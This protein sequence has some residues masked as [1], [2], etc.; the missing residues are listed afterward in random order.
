[1]FEKK[2]K[3]STPN[4]SYDTFRGRFG[5]GHALR[6]KNE[7]MEMTRAYYKKNPPQVGDKVVVIATA[8]HTDMWPPEHCVIE[9]IT[10]RGRI[11]VDHSHAYAWAGKSFWKS[12]Q[13]CKA[14]KGQV[15]LIPD[16]LYEEDYLSSEDLY[17]HKAKEREGKTT[18]DLAL[19][20]EQTSMDVGRVKAKGRWGQLPDA[21][22]QRRMDKL[23]S[24]LVYSRKK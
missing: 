15:W 11:V 24:K 20:M 6:D 10:D 19:E 23:L 5:H 4:A 9:A 13:N 7:D 21:E 18:L 12:G 14:P 1:M 8:S 17:A 2:D 16:E 3:K 22:R